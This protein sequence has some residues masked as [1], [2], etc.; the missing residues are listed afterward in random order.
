VT[1]PA[2]VVLDACTLE[3]FAVIKRLDLIERLFGE[4]AS[5]TSAVEQEIIRNAHDRPHLEPLLGASWLGDPIEFDDPVAIQGIE[6]I[7]RALGGTTNLPSQHL[8]EAQALYYAR[9][10]D[11]TVAIATDDRSAYAMGR[12]RGV[13]VIDS[14]EIARLTYTANLVGCPEAYQLLTEMIAA[15]RRIVVPPS[16]WH[17]C[18]S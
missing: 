8:G 2:R 12:T 10:V 17:V 18:P 14:A 16:H 13:Q 5:W 7:R 11:S 1:G 6:R 3:N 4:K 9:A 15:D